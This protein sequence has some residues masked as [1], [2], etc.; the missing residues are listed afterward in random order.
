MLEMVMDSSRPKILV[1]DDDTASIDIL[2]EMLGNDYDVLCATHGMTGIDIA[3]HS[4]P[5]VILLD[6]QMDGIDGYKVCARLKANPLTAHI[7]IIFVT[8]LDSSAQEV[9]G[10]EAGA[11]DFVKKPINAPVVCAR[12]RAHMRTGQ[13][14]SAPHGRPALTDCETNILR[15]C[16]AGMPNN[17]IAERTGLANTQVQHHLTSIIVKLG[18][19]VLT[20]E[21]AYLVNRLMAQ[22]Q[23][24]AGKLDMASPEP[25][26]NM[27]NHAW[28]DELT[29][30]QKEVLLWLCEGKTNWEIGKIL[31][32]TPDT[33]KYHV[34]Q[35]LLRL[36]VVSRAQAV[37]KVL[38]SP[39]P[40]RIC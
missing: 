2:S 26:R 38:A 22:P 23:A 25:T 6:I 3:V 31:G 4:L 19:N 29:S 20:N 8:G 13:S 21:Y 40:D 9:K 24:A 12:V 15:L 1:I 10:L 16:E 27:D 32:T 14:L 18:P 35:I 39:S 34:S 33:I 7:P 37:A 30:R 17:A 28:A 36:N 11:V 5:D